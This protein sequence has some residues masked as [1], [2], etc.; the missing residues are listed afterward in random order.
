MDQMRRAT[1]GWVVA[2]L[3]AIALML[4][5][6]LV[7]ARTASAAADG[8]YSFPNSAIADRAE[9]HANGASGGQCL[10]FVTN[11]IKSAGGPQ[12]Y[13]GLDTNTYQSQWAQRAASVGS[14]AEALRGDIVQWGGGA[15]GTLDPHTAIIT[16]AGSNPQVIDSNYGTAEKVSRGL[17]SSRSPAGSVYRLWRV[18]RGSSADSGQ[19]RFVAD[20]DGDR[21]SDVVRYNAADASWSVAQSS[22]AGFFPPRAWTS[23]RRTGSTKQFVA[24]VNGDGRADAITFFVTTGD[25]WAAIS[26]PPTLATCPRGC[27]RRT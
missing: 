14:L 6:G 16:V 12:F 13:F 9:A 18:G 23:G 4:S 17:L 20:V 8:P 27:P 24:D 26:S 11:M 7:G 3:A 19:Q 1:T 2:C 15:G 10:V 21:R 25:W 22:G 5:I